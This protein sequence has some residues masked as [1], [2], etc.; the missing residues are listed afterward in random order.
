MWGGVGGGLRLAGG[1]GVGVVG[2]GYDF[3]ALECGRGGGG[4]GGGMCVTT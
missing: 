2:P 3:G 1:G 4:G